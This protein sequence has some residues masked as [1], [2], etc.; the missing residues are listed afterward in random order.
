MNIYIISIAILIACGVL[1]K[2]HYEAY[3]YGVTSQVAEQKTTQDLIKQVKDDAMSG[4]AHVISNIDIKQV[5]IKGRLEKE[6]QTNTVYRDCL[7]S[8]DGLRAINDA[9]TNAVPGSIDNSQLPQTGET[10]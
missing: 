4:A 3:K 1:G 9:L 10:K 6:I 8:P 7:N 2:S 5:T